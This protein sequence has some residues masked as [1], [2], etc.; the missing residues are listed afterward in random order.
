[1]S[2]LLGLE[3]TAGQSEP[4]TVTRFFR[5]ADEW[6][7]EHLKAECVFRSPSEIVFSFGNLIPG[8]RSTAIEALWGLYFREM[9]QESARMGFTFRSSVHE[10]SE[11]GSESSIA[12]AR[13]LLRMAHGGQVL[14]SASAIAATDGQLREVVTPLGKYNLDL[15]GVEIELY[16]GVFD[17]FPS[18][19]SAPLPPRVAL[20]SLNPV[21][22]LATQSSLAE[23]VARVQAA[24]GASVARSEITSFL[25]SLDE[26]SHHGV[27]ALPAMHMLFVGLRGTGKMLMTNCVAE[28]LVAAGILKTAE[29]HVMDWADLAVMDHRRFD[30]LWEGIAGRV[31]CLTDGDSFAENPAIGRRSAV[32]ELVSRLLSQNYSLRRGIGD[33]Q[34]PRFLVGMFQRLDSWESLVRWEP[35]LLELA[36][37]PIAFEPLT[38]NELV[39]VFSRLA[40]RNEMSLAS[41]VAE[42]LKNE[43]AQL[44]PQRANARFIMGHFEAVRKQA[45][46]RRGNMTSDALTIEPSDLPSLGDGLQGRP[47]AEQL[48]SLSGMHGVVSGLERAIEQARMR[49]IRESERKGLHFILAGG[50]GCGK[51]TVSRLI[52]PLLFEAGYL[53]RP[54][55]VAVSASEILRKDS[56]PQG[57]LAAELYAAR[58]GVLVIDHAEELV[59]DGEDARWRSGWLVE[60]SRQLLGAM[61]THGAETTIVLIAS[62]EGATKLARQF[63]EL[64]AM[65]SRVDFSEFSEVNAKDAI[66]SMSNMLGIELDD[67]ARTVLLSEMKRRSRDPRFGNMAVLETLLRESA[68]S[69]LHAELATVQSED[70]LQVQKVLGS[71]VVTGESMLRV[72]ADP[73]RD[74]EQVLAELHSLTGLLEV[75]KQIME[76]VRIAENTLERAKYGL[77]SMQGSLHMAFLGNPGTGKTTVARIVGRLLHN[78]GILPS[79]AFVEVT[80]K[81]LIAGYIGQTAIKT[82]E[83]IDQARGGV[84]FVDEAYSIKSDAG[85]NSF[86]DEALSEL[87]AAM[88]N[89]RQSMV[90]IFA[91]YTEQTMRLIEENPGLPSRFARF[92]EFPDYGPSELLNIVLGM[93]RA[94]DYKIDSDALPLVQ[95]K[96][97]RLALAPNFANA[98]AARRLIESAARVQAVRI[99]KDGMSLDREVLMLLNKEDFESVSV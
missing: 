41:G 59:R 90:V 26:T 16:S 49:D 38:S 9:C 13:Q 27:D 63:P 5:Y 37:S 77:T 61:A 22:S 72:V 87:V 14:V 43:L 73:D 8:A 24:S 70:D 40:E 81:D 51:S 34:S 35:A 94:N 85:G 74:Y 92:I 79:N 68:N 29:P 71:L 69:A 21:E 54:V 50:P 25:E 4:Q 18:V 1:M 52:G 3:C 23:I 56:S 80:A 86:G 78:V 95:S 89:Y 55:T 99:T 15:S 42:T 64:A 58:G 53:E 65:A 19:L 10:N 45:F 91:G 47:A 20:A 28:G 75:K 83:A 12:E 84:L 33:L 98:R 66:A 67:A 36:E 44:D 46:R 88:E 62:P 7:R 57:L 31:L 60:A 76:I 93:A 97:E 17:E 39:E 30:E 48:R 2:I 82:A 6:M 32:R 96:L 11:S